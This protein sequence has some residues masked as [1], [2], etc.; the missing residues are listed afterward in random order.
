[1]A[2]F[3][4]SLCLFAVA[5]VICHLVAVFMVHQGLQKDMNVAYATAMASV[6]LW[7]VVRRDV[8]DDFQ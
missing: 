4:I 5:A 8:K 1:M 2:K 6:A 7:G 3:I